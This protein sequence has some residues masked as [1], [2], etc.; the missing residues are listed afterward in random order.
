MM[1][2]YFFLHPV[3][4]SLLCACTSKIHVD[5]GTNIYKLMGKNR[6]LALIL[7]LPSYY[8]Y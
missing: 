8:S 5:K 1:R 6:A 3:L 2:K 4:T 7:F